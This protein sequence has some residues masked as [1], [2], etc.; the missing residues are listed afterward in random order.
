[1]NL[2]SHTL[3][4]R[5]KPVLGHAQ[6]IEDNPGAG[7]QG[8]NE[9]LQKLHTVL[10]GPVVEDGAEEVDVSPLDRLLRS[11]KVMTRES[12]SVT[13]FVRHSRNILLSRHD[14]LDSEVESRK[15]FRKRNADVAFAAANIDNVQTFARQTVCFEIFYD[16][17]DGVLDCPNVHETTKLLGASLVF[18]LEFV[19]HWQC[20]L[21]SQ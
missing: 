15:C 8:W 4:G 10:V 5:C 16:G 3:N 6:V 13:N 9:V 20:S 2:P 7:L 17:L 21:I 18:G 19:V 1:M 14:I 12:D 11:E